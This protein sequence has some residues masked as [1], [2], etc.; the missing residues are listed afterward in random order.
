MRL[1]GYQQFQFF[2]KRKTNDFPFLR[3]FCARKNVAFV[4]FCSLVFVLLAVFCL[5]C[6]FVHLKAFCKER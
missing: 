2:S 1:S 3:H 4:V 6:V 5:I